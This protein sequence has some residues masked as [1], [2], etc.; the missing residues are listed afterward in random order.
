MSLH[1]FEKAADLSVVSDPPAPW[2]SE[3]MALHED[4]DINDH[5]NLTADQLVNRI[6]A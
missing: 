6:E 4:A 5:L 1:V 2:V 3:Q